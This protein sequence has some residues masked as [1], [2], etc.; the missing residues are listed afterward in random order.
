MC[1]H[2]CVSELCAYQHMWLLAERR[3]DEDHLRAADRTDE[4]G[5]QSLR[6]RARV[7]LKLAEHAK[8]Y[9]HT[10]QLSTVDIPPSSAIQP[11]KVGN[12]ASQDL[13]MT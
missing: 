3:E 10:L 1:P 9:K 6:A 4:R 8:E 12:F 13:R 2:A 7:S 5:F 11:T